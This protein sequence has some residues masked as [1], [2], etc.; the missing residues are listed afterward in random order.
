MP[1]IWKA[2]VHVLW[3]FLWVTCFAIPGAA[4]GAQKESI[5]PNPEYKIGSTDL[6]EIKIL[7]LPELNQAVRVSEDGFIYH[8]LIGKVDVRRLSVLELEKRLVAILNEKYTK[9]A[10]VVILIKEFQKASVLG[11]VGKPGEYELM[12][13]TTLLQMI[14]KAEGLTAQASNEILI[15]RIND[16]GVQTRIVISL[17]DL[18]IAGKQDANLEVLP[19]DVVTVPIEETLNVFVYGEVKTPGVVSFLRSKKIT[20]LQAVAQAGGPTEWANK[21][22]V[23]IKRKERIS[24]KE[25]KIPANL[26]LIIKG[27][28]PD[29]ALQ[30]GD[31]VIVS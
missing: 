16:A 21:R 26:K 11:A 29:I 1:N 6:L 4:A 24:G 27:K 28:N 2:A 12:G 3:G 10:H 14:A 9:D 22:N 13:P 19:K 20:L 5:L 23:I 30:E 8:S 17:D 25:I 31:V 18:M 7:E 15:Y